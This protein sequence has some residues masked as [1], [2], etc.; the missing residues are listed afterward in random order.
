MRV[1]AEL[2]RFCDDSF[3]LKRKS[4]TTA[5]GWLGSLSARLRVP[6]PFTLVKESQNERAEMMM[7]KPR[8]R[9]LELRDSFIG[10][11][12][13]LHSLAQGPLSLARPLVLLW[14]S[15]LELRPLFSC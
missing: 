5:L 9:S 6:R 3:F 1:A 11:D 8:P 12:G 13:S 4:D 14:D 10:G 15:L 7:G 2:W